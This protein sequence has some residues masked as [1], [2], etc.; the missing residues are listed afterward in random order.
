MRWA[1]LVASA[2]VAGGAAAPLGWI[3]TDRLEQDNDFCNACHLTPEIP[4][5]IDIRR[6]F[7][8]APAAT[9][10][11][12]HAGED[13][14]RSDSRFRCIDCHGGHSAVGRAR[15]KALAAKDAFWWLVGS[16]EEPD[17]MRWPL[18]DEDCAKCH[19]AFDES[20]AEP[21]QAS[22]FHQ[23]PVHNVEL[24]V[25]CVECHRTH[26]TGG[27]PGGYFLHATWVRSQCAR[28]HSEFE[29][30]ER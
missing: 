7:D 30:G 3:V 20:D 17:G 18:W 10:A 1:R 6:D 22:R 5:H 11:A 25:D 4:L 19:D 16:F 15:V 28:C 8:A 24:G 9:L 26:A 13:G 2:A 27:D 21:W 29:E 23:L 14:P 12:L